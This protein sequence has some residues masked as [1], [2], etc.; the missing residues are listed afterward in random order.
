[1]NTAQKFDI[2]DEKL[3]CSETMKGG[4][5]L[6]CEIHDCIKVLQQGQR[7]HSVFT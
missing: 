1:M 5:S 2:K 4:G 7:M 3:N 6:F